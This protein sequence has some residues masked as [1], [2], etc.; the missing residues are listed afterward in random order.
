[1]RPKPQAQGQFLI[2]QNENQFHLL[3]QNCLKRSHGAFQQMNEAVCVQGGVFAHASGLQMTPFQAGQ[4]HV[5]MARLHSASGPRYPRGRF[6]ASLPVCPLLE[7][8]H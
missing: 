8:S 1:M 2:F 4:G 7:S 3:K 6:D 5:R